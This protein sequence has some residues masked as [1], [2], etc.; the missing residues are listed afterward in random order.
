MK[1]GRLD[2]RIKI[3]R[4]SSTQNEYGEE[5]AGWSDLANI[6]AEVR[7][8]SGNESFTENQFLAKADTTFRIRWSNVTKTITA[9]DRILFDGRYFDITAIREIGR[10]EGLEL[11]AFA[12]GEIEING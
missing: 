10:A 3:Q 4:N 1:A 8:A 2:Q 9:L 5:I 11:D 12:R 6:W 7:P